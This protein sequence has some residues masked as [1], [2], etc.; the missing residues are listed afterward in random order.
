MTSFHVFSINFVL[1]HSLMVQ[2][3]I[4]L[5]LQFSFNLI[6]KS[7]GAFFCS[8][9]DSPEMSNLING[10]CTHFLTHLLILFLTLEFVLKMN[11][12]LYCAS[13]LESNSE[14]I[15]LYVNVPIEITFTTYY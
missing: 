6:S 11:A 10:L 2:L 3:A 5:A 7:I 15:H 4:A 13:R 14:A 1:L 9:P 8:F 12:N